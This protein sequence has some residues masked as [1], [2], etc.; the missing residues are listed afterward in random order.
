MSLEQWVLDR[1]AHL[2]QQVDWLE[3]VQGR[4]EEQQRT[5][6]RELDGDAFPCT[7]EW[8]PVEQTMV[9]VPS[10]STIRTKLVE[11]RGFLQ[12]TEDKSELVREQNKEKKR[13][14]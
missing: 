13:V 7:Q 2:E 1:L 11:S 14:N 8:V 12:K 3:G 4:E 5:Q 10:G 9:T 6:V